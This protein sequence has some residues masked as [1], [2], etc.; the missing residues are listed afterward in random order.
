MIVQTT[1]AVVTHQL[2]HKSHVYLFLV[3]LQFTEADY[4]QILNPELASCCCY[5]SLTESGPEEVRNY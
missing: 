1:S 2:K 4:Q 3:H 5:S